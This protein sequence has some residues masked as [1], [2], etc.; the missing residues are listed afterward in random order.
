MIIHICDFC[1]TKITPNNISKK[2]GIQTHMCL[3]NPYGMN[4]EMEMC[5]DCS[6]KVAEALL[7]LKDESIEA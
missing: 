7:K 5:S 6:D 4:V 1:G 3:T 2:I